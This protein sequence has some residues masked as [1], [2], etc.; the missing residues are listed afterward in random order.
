MILGFRG[1]PGNIINYGLCRKGK[2]SSGWTGHMSYVIPE[3]THVGLETICE[4]PRVRCKYH[5]SLWGA[6]CPDRWSLK[7]GPVPQRVH[8]MTHQH[9]GRARQDFQYNL[10]CVW[11]SKRKKALQICRRQGNTED[12]Q[13]ASVSQLEMCSKG[14]MGV[15][16]GEW[17]WH[18]LW[19]IHLS[20]ACGVSQ[21]SGDRC[22]PRRSRCHEDNT[23][24]WYSQH[25]ALSCEQSF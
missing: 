21:F 1:P 7:W 2:C 23:F 4:T 8:R 16:R 12:F 20:E 3:E 19:F 14:H 5:K 15:P 10:S 13:Q 6:S 11:K 24:K 22:R 18:C 9:V 17:V 25:C